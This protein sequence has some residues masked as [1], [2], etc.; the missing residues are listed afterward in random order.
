MPPEYLVIGH[1]IFFIHLAR[2]RK[3]SQGVVSLPNSQY[4]GN[5]LPLASANMDDEDSDEEKARIEIGEWNWR[6]DDTFA[7]VMSQ[8]HDLGSCIRHTSLRVKRHQELLTKGVIEGLEEYSGI[9]HTLPVLVKLH[10]DAM[11]VYN[12]SKQKGSVC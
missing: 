1:F 6:D 3:P 7:H 8:L 10:E 9:V 12:E 4:S 11:A 2:Y 5:I